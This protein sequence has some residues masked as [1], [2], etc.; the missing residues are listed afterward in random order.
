MPEGLRHTAHEVHALQQGMLQCGMALLQMASPQSD[1]QRVRSLEGE[2]VKTFEELQE[3][4]RVSRDQF[5]AAFKG[6]PVTCSCRKVTVPSYKLYKCYYCGVFH[7]DKC[8][9]EHFG[10]TREEYNE[11]HYA[12]CM[13]PRSAD[14]VRTGRPLLQTQ[15][16]VVEA[17]EQAPAEGVPP[18]ERTSPYS[19]TLSD[20]EAEERAHLCDQFNCQAA[21]GERDV[22]NCVNCGGEL[23]EKE[24][25]WY[26]W[27]Q[28]DQ[29]F[30]GPPQ[31]YV[32]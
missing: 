15:E 1:E 7:C 2:E 8:A 5:M 4:K 11:E 22:T 26:H 10:Q 19:R 31:D 14:V 30:L 21:P 29:G 17:D 20:A 28:F 6:E 13:V 23:R 25:A 24:G 16:E 9:A 12:E 18:S 27:S 32:S 3:S